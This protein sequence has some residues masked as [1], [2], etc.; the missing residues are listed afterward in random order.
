M[1]KSLSVGIFVL[2]FHVVIANIKWEEP[3]DGT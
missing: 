1:G 3:L 2:S